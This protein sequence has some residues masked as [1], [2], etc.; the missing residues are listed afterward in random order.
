MKSILGTGA[1]LV[2]TALT[3]GCGFEIFEDVGTDPHPPTVVITALVH[4]VPPPTPTPTPPPEDRVASSE[5][6]RAVTWDSGGFTLTTGQQFYIARSY[7][8]AGGDIVNFHLRDRDG[9]TTKDLTPTDQTYFS[10]TSGSGPVMLTEPV[11]GTVPAAELIEV[12]GIFGQHRLEFWA[13]D[14]H[15]SRSEKIEFIIT[16]AP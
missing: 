1:L 13:E 6:G 15:G 16:L 12:V 3:A 9:L 8:D 5:Q 14:S 11:A 7:T 2:L 4:Y 10:G